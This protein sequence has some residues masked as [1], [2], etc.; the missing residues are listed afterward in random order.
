M[1]Q[2]MKEEEGGEKDAEDDLRTPLCFRV[3]FSCPC[4]SRTL[5]PRA[6]DKL[7][8]PGTSALC[9]RD[10]RWPED[11]PSAC[12]FS[13][14][15]APRYPLLSISAAPGFAPDYVCSLRRS[16]ICG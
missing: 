16:S 15:R 11:A 4:A 10:C 5:G 14:P 3:F 1:P 8:A 6:M 7:A 9:S 12:V 13:T 2:Q